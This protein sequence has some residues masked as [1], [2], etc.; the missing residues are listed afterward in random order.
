VEIPVNVHVTPKFIMS[1]PTRDA[2][3]FMNKIFPGIGD[4]MRVIWLTQQRLSTN[5]NTLVEVQEA[6]VGLADVVLHGICQRSFTN[7]KMLTHETDG[8]SGNERLRKK[9]KKEDFPVHIP[10]T[11]RDYLKGEYPHL[12]N[13]KLNIFCDF[14][15]PCQK[16]I[17]DC[18]LDDIFSDVP[19]V[20][21]VLLGCVHE[22]DVQKAYEVIIPESK[23]SAQRF[24]M[25]DQFYKNVNET[26]QGRKKE[27]E[28][29]CIKSVAQ[30]KMCV[31]YP[32]VYKLEKAANSDEAEEDDDEDFAPNPE[33]D[34]AALF[35]GHDEAFDFGE[36]VKGNMS[37]DRKIA[38][39]ALIA[40]KR[41]KVPFHLL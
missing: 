33:D 5:A 25:F 29:G 13:E 12:I 4:Q 30:E 2:V 11:A 17:L 8:S 1:E 3:D 31:I 14:F 39:G 9:S 38:S 23:R 35:V 10:K 18:E 20:W 41:Q 6:C 32:H 7:V 36:A 28:K 16:S 21:N 19:A 24:I 22:A 27:S 37:P 34:S 15:Y 26:L 40:L